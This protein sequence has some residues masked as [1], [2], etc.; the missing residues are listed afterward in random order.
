MLTVDTRHG[1]DVRHGRRELSLEIVLEDLGPLHGLVH[2]HARDV[3]T[4]ND[5]VVRVDHRQHLG[6]G[7]KDILASLRVDT[8]PDGRGSDQRAD[9]VRLLDAVLGVPRHAVLVGEVSRQHG[10][11]V[12][13]SK[14]DQ[15][16]T[17]V[18]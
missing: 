15:K 17:G 5:K 16:K 8:E 13:S 10:G 9:V 2:G 7:H 14:T 12:V 1:L 18:S 6:H 11:A 4:A 3:P